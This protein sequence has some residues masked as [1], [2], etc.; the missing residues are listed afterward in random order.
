MAGAAIS[1]QDLL[2][3]LAEGHAAGIT[4]VTPNLRLARELAREFDERQAA[5]GLTVWE[6]ADILPFSA[7]AERCYEEA[8]YSGAGA[9][10][11]VLLTAAQER[12]LWEEAI[13]ASS[14]AGALLDVPRTAAQAMQAW[15]LAHAWRIAGALAKFEGSEDCRAFAE[16]ARAYERRL[17]KDGLVDTATL[18]D[19]ALMAPKTKLLVAYA[20]DILPPQAEDLLRRF[21]AGFCAPAARAGSAGRAPFA[22]QQEELDAA[23]RWA[24]G[25]LE[26]GAKRVGVVVPQLPERRREAARVFSRVMRP[27]FNIPASA[28]EALPF[29]VSAGEPLIA[30]P[31]V[32]FALA[33]L[34][35]ARGEL[36]FEAAS[37]LIRSP[38]LGGADTEYA[39]RAKLDARLRKKAGA[40]ISLPA[41]IAR[42]ESCALL[43]ARLEA[44]FAVVARGHSP[45]DWARYFTAVLEAAG[46]PGERRLEPAEYQARGK[47]NEM[48]REFARLASVR[49]RLDSGEALARLKGLCADTL[50]QPE[51]PDAPVQVLGLLE[52][53][54]LEFDALWVSGLT[55][56]AWPLR[57]QP[58]PFLPIALQRRAG[59][60]EASAESSLALDRRRTEGWARAAAEVVFSWPR[61]EEDRDLAPSSLIGRFEERRPAVPD[62]PRYRDS[63]FALR[64]LE[65]VQDDQAP[66]LGT[67]AAH[68][69]T[70]VLVDQAACPFRAFA[71]HRLR[72]ERLESPVPGLDALDRGKLLHALMAGIWRA[73]KSSA[74]LA[75]DLGPTIERAAKAAVK[76]L[77]LEGRFAEIEAA[78][79]VRLAGEWLKLERRRE[80]FRVAQIEEPVEMEIG[81]LRL[82]GRIDRLDRLADGTHAVIDYK[83]GSRVTP[84]DWLEERPDDPQLP[85]YAV[86]AQQRVAVVAFAKVRPG[87]M[88]F[89]GLAAKKGAIPGVKPARSWAAL[90]SGWRKGLE[91]LAAE[92]AEGRAQV[93]PKR[94]LETC[95][96]CDL[97]TL[98]RVHEKLNVLAEPAWEEEEE[99]A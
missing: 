27:G 30:Y 22:S 2:A 6:T 75:K 28:R 71:R 68:G 93:D 40:R 18:P 77:E 62:Y 37:R 47:W 21:A 16:W 76:E 70:R 36:E 19:L 49:E 89:A 23:A 63:I 45:H 50:F 39:A 86:T 14:W 26:A 97:H 72:A 78:R 5:G 29:N 83:T 87:D 66:A 13:R 67:K 99:R 38:F 24:R 96:S 59:I 54:S 52:S 91:R 56:D 33:L 12:A 34:E 48:L 20:F 31:L 15:R 42:V 4:V 46:F 65:R 32:A 90:L 55:D 88:K 60:P 10:L 43:R 58:N 44:V 11:P 17:G 82:K 57:A 74:A 85:L 61:R 3:R 41:M 92:F 53:V 79:L 35:F 98:C 84:R 25:K 80:D 51:A 73:A 64:S 7:F 1:K 8:L 9:A 95:R 69:G 94:G 81:R